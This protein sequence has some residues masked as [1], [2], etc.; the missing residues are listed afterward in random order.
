MRD[1]YVEYLRQAKFANRP[2]VAKYEQG[3]VKERAP[4]ISVGRRF[5]KSYPSRLITAMSLDYLTQKKLGWKRYMAIYPEWR[6]IC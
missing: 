2:S 4:I 5:G 3:F 6:I 1:D